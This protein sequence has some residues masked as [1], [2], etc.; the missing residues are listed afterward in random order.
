[1]I[2]KRS[3]IKELDTKKNKIQYALERYGCYLL[4]LSTVI[5]LIVCKINYIN[6]P[7]FTTALEGVLGMCSLIVGFAR[8]GYG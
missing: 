8:N 1:M 4:T 6:N 7:N 2:G 3:Y 5:L